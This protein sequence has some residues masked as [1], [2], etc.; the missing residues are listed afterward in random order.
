MNKSGVLILILTIILASCLSLCSCFLSPEPP[1]SSEME[2]VL[3][4]YY[5]ELVVVRD[6]LLS[7]EYDTASINF[8]RDNTMRY[9]ANFKYHDINDADT[10]EAL[11]KLIGAG[12][13]F[14]SKDLSSNRVSFE[15]W[16]S[17]QD[18]GC[19]V[20][21]RI[22]PDKKPKMQFLTELNETETDGWF[23]YVEDYNEWRREHS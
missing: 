3:N 23:T 15:L 17:S 4:E 13:S 14:I 12:C 1:S 19:G 22:N 18:I 10:V 7:I 5:S 16:W 21:Y 2:G 8:Y 6:Y 11:K 9:F 20:L